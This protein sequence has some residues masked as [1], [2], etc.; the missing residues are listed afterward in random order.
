MVSADAFCH[1]DRRLR[2]LT[3]NY[4]QLF[5]DLDIIMCG[6]RRQLPSVRTSEVYRRCN[7]QD[8]VFSSVV[9]WQHL[10]YFPLHQVMRQ[11]D[12][13]FSAILTKIGD[14][15]ALAPEQ[16]RL[17]ESLFESSDGAI[18]FAPDAMRLFYFNADV[19]IFNTEIALE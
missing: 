5:G 9:K 8:K 19:N 1:I 7:G 4:D 13:G 17:L 6:D 12:A 10:S 2:Q 11:K 3:Y 16:V 14:G 15:M 18:I